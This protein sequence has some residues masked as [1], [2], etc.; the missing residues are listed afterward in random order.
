[1]FPEHAASWRRSLGWAPVAALGG[2]GLAGLAE[3]VVWATA[4]LRGRAWLAA[5]PPTIAAEV[6]GAAASLKPRLTNLLRERAGGRGG[7]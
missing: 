1:M 3:R 5:A 4:T 2:L 7:N 6:V